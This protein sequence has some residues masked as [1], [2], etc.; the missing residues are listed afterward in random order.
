M[1]GSFGYEKEHFNTSMAIANQRLF[2]E[3]QKAP[4]STLIVAPG[5]SCRSQIFDGLHA[6]ALHPIQIL[7]RALKTP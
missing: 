5:T 6:E 3:I 7:D 1:A 2:P 4:E